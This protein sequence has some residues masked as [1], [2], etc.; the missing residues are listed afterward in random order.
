MPYRTEAARPMSDVQ[1]DQIILATAAAV[2]AILEA[3]H[4][5]YTAPLHAMAENLAA[6]VVDAQKEM[7]AA[8]YRAADKEET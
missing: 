6:M 1:R 3:A 7:S 2:A 4:T 8:F 5:N